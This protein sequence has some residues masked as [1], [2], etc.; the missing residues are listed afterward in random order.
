MKETKK[1]D[2]IMRHTHTHTHTHKLVN[3]MALTQDSQVLETK[4]DLG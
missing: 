4:E 1:H 3:V 2:K